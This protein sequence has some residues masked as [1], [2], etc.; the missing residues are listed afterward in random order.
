MRF[1]QLARRSYFS[2]CPR[3][4]TCSAAALCPGKHNGPSSELLSCW[5][6][7]CRQSRYPSVRSSLRTNGDPNPIA[8]RGAGHPILTTDSSDSIC[9]RTDSKG[10]RRGTLARASR[11]ICWAK[12]PLIVVN[13]LFRSAEAGSSEALG[14]PLARYQYGK[15]LVQSG[16][17]PAAISAAL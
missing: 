17:A 9:S 5:W 3:G 2:R 8:A 13:P 12:L 14:C 15:R 6:V 16:A 7:R 4:L 11:S 10:A 1:A